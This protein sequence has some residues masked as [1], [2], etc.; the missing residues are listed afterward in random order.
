MQTYLLKEAFN[1]LM[2]SIVYFVVGMLVLCVVEAVFNFVIIGL[3][4]AGVLSAGS[5]ILKTLYVMQFITVVLII[6]GFFKMAMKASVGAKPEFTDLFDSWRS[7][8]K[9][10]VAWILFCVLMMLFMIPINLFLAWWISGKSVFNMIL[11]PLVSLVPVL[12]FMARLGFFIPI[13]LEKD[14]GP[15]QALIESWN[16]TDGQ[17]IPIGIFVFVLYMMNIFGLFL[18][19]IG[20]FLTFPL[21]IIAWACYF[22]ELMVGSSV[23]YSEAYQKMLEQ[24]S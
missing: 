8:W 15:L 23:V 4:V 11:F 20:F 19:G 16:L 13:I 24:G 22:R 2:Q 1:K 7:L 21:T 5:W 18:F 3:Q 14:A 12:Y 10:V 17:Y 9:V 6:T